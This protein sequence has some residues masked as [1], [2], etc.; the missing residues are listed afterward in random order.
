MFFGD[1]VFSSLIKFVLMKCFGLKHPLY[2]RV[3]FM[4]VVFFFKNVYITQTAVAFNPVGQVTHHFLCAARHFSSFKY[5]FFFRPLNF[6]LSAFL[7][8]RILKS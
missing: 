5:T 8:Q 6:N 7:N 3:T 2:Y 4:C 1:E